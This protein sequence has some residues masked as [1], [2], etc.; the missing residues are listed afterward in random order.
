MPNTMNIL[1]EL[2]QNGLRTPNAE[3]IEHSFSENG[4]PS[5]GGMFDD[6][7]GMFTSGNTAGAAAPS[8]VQ[9][10]GGG[11]LDQLRSLAGAGVRDTGAQKA[12]GI[13]ALAGALLGGGGKSIK[14]AI[15]GGALAWLGMMAI[16]AFRKA[17]AKTPIDASAKLAA[18]LR[19]PENK[20]EEREVESIADL[21]LKAM[22]NAAKADGRIDETE[23]QRIT[24]R[25]GELDSEER[26]FLINEL[27]KPMNTDAIVNAIPNKQVAAQV[28][29]A[30]LLATGNDTP[31]EHRYLADLA[32]RSGLDEGVTR[33]LQ[34]AINVG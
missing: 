10:S 5:K 32:R 15:G 20:A 1:G 25:L 30:S 16:Q 3:R 31:E 28:Y 11:F 13:G 27:R 7:I 24:G 14:G 4:I 18:G 26:E 22:I 17:G 29:T 34:G 21:T 9:A 12:G 2:F 19:A 23:M 33:Y 8:Q 6:L